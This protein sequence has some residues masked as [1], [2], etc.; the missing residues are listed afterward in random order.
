MPQSEVAKLIEHGKT[1]PGDFVPPPAHE[2]SNWWYVEMYICGVRILVPASSPLTPPSCCS[3][4][5][6]GEMDMISV[7]EVGL[8]RPLC[9]KYRSHVTLDSGVKVPYAFDLMVLE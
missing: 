8:M 3:V 4:S 5:R 1:L 9:D 2:W 6:R 7:Y